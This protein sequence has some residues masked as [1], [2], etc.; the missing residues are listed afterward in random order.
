MAPIDP[1]QLLA[2]FAPLLTPLG[3][4]K[5]ATEVPRLSS[6]MK[7]FSRKL[8]SRCV[9]CNVLLATTPDV[10][11]EFLRSGGWETIHLWI[12]SAK[13]T[14]NRPFLD[15]LLKLLLTL[16]MNVDRLR[17]NESPKM[18][19]KLAKQMDDPLLAAKAQEVVDKWTK[20]IE[21]NAISGVKEKKRKSNDTNNGGKDSG[22]AKKSKL[23][24]K[25]AN[26]TAESDS[27]ASMDSSNSDLK[28]TSERTPRPSTAKVKPGK[29]RL[30]DLVSQSSAKPVKQR[31]E[32]KKSITSNKPLNNA[33]NSDSLNSVTSTSLPKPKI[34][35]IGGIKVIE[36]LPVTTAA[37]PAP[38]PVPPPVVVPPAKPHVL[39]VCLELI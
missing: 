39:H 21:L 33:Y 30:G 35:P 16:P 15:E 31:K 13:D 36:P 20:M 7:K 26:H 10:L 4:I 18:I 5:N 3:G 37:A 8:V 23:N 25:S 9:Y 19:R 24:A 28:A 17:E 29:S 12:K 2:A 11:E 6:L 22:D 38:T 14:G 27:N 1:N 34:Q 32:D